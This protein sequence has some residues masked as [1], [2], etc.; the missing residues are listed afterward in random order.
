M[1]NNRTGF[2]IICYLIERLGYKVEDAIKEFAEK[3]APGIKHDHFV[4]ELYVRY[5]VKMQRRGTIVG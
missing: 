3:R 4:N 2:F 5:A 1:C